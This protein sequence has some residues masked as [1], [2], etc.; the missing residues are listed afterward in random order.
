MKKTS[1][2]RV[3]LVAASFMCVWGPVA[4]QDK[5]KDFAISVACTQVP[6]EACTWLDAE[7]YSNL[8][9]TVKSQMRQRFCGTS[10]VSAAQRMA[11]VNGSS[12]FPNPECITALQRLREL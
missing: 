1:V 11:K 5:V 4:A 12:E 3:A 9:A 8:T 2:I 10:N 6:L 7:N